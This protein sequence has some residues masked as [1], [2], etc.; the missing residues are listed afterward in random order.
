M[1]F[2]AGLLHQGAAAGKLVGGSSPIGAM[3]SSAMSRARRDLAL[4]GPAGGVAA[5]AD[6]SEDGIAEGAFQRI[7]GQTAK[8]FQMTDPGLEGGSAAQVVDRV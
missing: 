1:V 6:C 3:V 4:Q 8:G 7:A 2:G 5:G